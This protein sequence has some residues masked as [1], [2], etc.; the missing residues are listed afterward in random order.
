MSDCLKKYWRFELSQGAVGVIPEPSN[1]KW[2]SF[3]S[4]TGI[5]PLIHTPRNT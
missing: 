4:N 2:A 5:G 1:V 3:R